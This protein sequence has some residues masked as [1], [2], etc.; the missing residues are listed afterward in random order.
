MPFVDI[1]TISVKKEAA[2]AK[3]ENVAINKE[4]APLANSV[5]K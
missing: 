4:P 2:P 5:H 1:E 3:N